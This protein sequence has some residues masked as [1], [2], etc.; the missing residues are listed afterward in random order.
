MLSLGD[1]IDVIKAKTERWKLLIN[2]F[3]KQVT[4]IDDLDQ[5]KEQ[6]QGLVDFWESIKM[7]SPVAQLNAIIGVV[8]PAANAKEAKQVEVV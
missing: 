6:L 5:S 4:N 2:S 3:Q 7:G 8:A 1:Y